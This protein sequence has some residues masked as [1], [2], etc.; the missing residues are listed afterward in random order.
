MRL[1]L[2]LWLAITVA[3]ASPAQSAGLLAAVQS[4]FMPVVV[5]LEINRQ[6]VGDAV[7]AAC[8]VIDSGT[9]QPGRQPAPATG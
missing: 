8:V 9:C 4:E 7:V 2:W 6:R 1:I 5:Q 3:I